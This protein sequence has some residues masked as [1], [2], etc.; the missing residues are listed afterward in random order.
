MPHN[1]KMVGNRGKQSE[2]WDLQILVQHTKFLWGTFVHRVSI[3]SVHGSDQGRLIMKGEEIGL[4]TSASIAV[5]QGPNL[6]LSN[7]G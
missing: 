2:I 3:L 1:T 6:V 7:Y 5:R 4:V